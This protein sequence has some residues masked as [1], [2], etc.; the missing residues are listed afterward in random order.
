MVELMSNHVSS[1][2][3]MSV[4]TI[5][6]LIILLIGIP[7]MILTNDDTKSYIISRFVF[8]VT[9]FFIGCVFYGATQQQGNL[10]EKNFT[11]VRYGDQLHV[12]SKT[13]WLQSKE[14]TIH[15]ENDDFVYI[16]DKELY[17][18]KK[19]EIRKP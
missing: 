5:V 13:P 6:A 19:R 4:V 9:L 7:T 8:A 3:W 18:I 15:S 11:A 17:E 12:T 1:P 2:M 14:F 10:K 16:K